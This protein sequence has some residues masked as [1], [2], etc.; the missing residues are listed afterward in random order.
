MAEFTYNATKHNATGPA[1]FEADMGRVTRLPR[2]LLAPTVR[3]HSESAGQYAQRMMLDLR[4]LRERLEEAQFSMTVEANKH[5]QPHPFWIGHQVFLDTRK[6]P[7]AYVNMAKAELGKSSRKFQHLYV[8]PF[9]LL[10]E[11]KPNAFVL[12]I[13]KG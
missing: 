4:M 1:P 3:T 5:Q 13:P 12:H 9:R 8:E 6:L 11:A 7:G 2:D 10:Q